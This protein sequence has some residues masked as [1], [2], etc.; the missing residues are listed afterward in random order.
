[1]TV[2][3]ALDRLAQRDPEALALVRG[4]RVGLLAHPASV[5][6]SLVHAKDVLVSAGASVCALFGPEHGYG[7]EAQDMIGVQNASDPETGAPVHSLY[8]DAFESLSP[9][10]EWLDGLDA[11]VVDLQDVGSRYYTFVWTAVLCAR[12]CAAAGIELIVL[13]RPNPLGGIAVEGAP[14]RAELRSFVGLRSVPVRH[15]LTIGE[16]V[17]EAA[18]DE[19]LDNVRVLE[20]QGWSR[21]MLFADTGLPWVLPS[22]NM[23]TADTALVYPGGCLLEGTNVSEGRG[24][25]RPFELFGAPFVD[26]RALALAMREDGGPGMIARATTFHPT[27]HKWARQNVGGVQVH[28][29][30]PRAFQPYRAYLAALRALRRCEGFAWRTE[31]YEFIDD[32]PA[33]DLL[34][35]DPLVRELIDQGAPVD[36]LVRVGADRL[37]QY[38]ARARWLYPR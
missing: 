26:H 22:P 33:V 1:M 4:R 36:E 29:T 13:D 6:R 21:E 2:L 12:A 27:F 20:M 24:T 8:G 7:G 15:G 25:T 5:T 32:V 17:M 28:V 14:Q 10:R 16:I 23:P 18:R 31:K 11:L 37:A 9:R 35:G 19:G 3:T 30:D 34:T 38:D